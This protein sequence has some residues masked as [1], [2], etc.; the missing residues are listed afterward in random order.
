MELED[1][2]QVEASFHDRRASDKR[3][4][5]ARSFEDAYPNKKLYAVTRAHRKRMAAWI[6]RYC[7]GATT[8]DFCCGEGEGAIKM[9]RAG[10]TVHGIDISAESLSLAREASTD[11]PNPPVFQVMDAEAMQFPDNHFDAIYAAGCLHHLDLD[12]TYKE[13]HRVLK[14]NG[15]IICNESLAHN[16]VFQTYR[17]RT[18]RLR[19]PWEVPHILRVGDIQRASQYFESVDIHFHYLTSLLAV[20]LRHTPV[21]KPVLTILEA[22]DSVLLRIPGLQLMAWQSTFEL[23]KPKNKH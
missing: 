13:L 6:E 5:D 11:L 10:A 19:T 20:P 23:S 18:P 16:P 4:Q 22:I 15:R 14:P 9:A 3:S 2:K 8:L 17:K 12:R 1:R 21:F 7:P